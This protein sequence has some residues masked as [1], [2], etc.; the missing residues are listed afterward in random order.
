MRHY[1]LTNQERA[2]SGFTDQFVI[3]GSELTGAV[4]TLSIPLVTLTNA[5]VDPQAVIRVDEGITG[6]V[7]ATLKAEVGH[8]KINGAGSVDPNYFIDQTTVKS[9]TG[10]DGTLIG[11]VGAGAAV[12]VTS[13]TVIDCTITTAGAGVQNFGTATKTGQISVFMKIIRGG[14]LGYDQA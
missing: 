12:V 5:L 3:E 6:T 11:P 2:A 14:D 9:A 8:D 13:S 7:G 1:V 4:Q 10:I